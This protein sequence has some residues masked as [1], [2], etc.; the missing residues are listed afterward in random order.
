M[1]S[2]SEMYVSAQRRYNMLETTDW[3]QLCI[4]FYTAEMHNI[5]SLLSV[6][7]DLSLSISGAV[8]I[9]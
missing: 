8:I 2:I 1:E 5:W 9:Y 7:L 4:G 6:G 3:F